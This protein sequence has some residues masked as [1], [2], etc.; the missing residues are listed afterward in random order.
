[1]NALDSEMA[2]V[3]REA[4]E[5]VSRNASARVV[6]L[7]GGALVL[8]GWRHWWCAY[9]PG[10]TQRLRVIRMPEQEPSRPMHGAISLARERIVPPMRLIGA[11]AS[12][13]PSRPLASRPT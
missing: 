10:G 9:A 5:A 4:I 1:M 2:G 11:E 13:A 8:R 3:L 6:V 7:R 12:P